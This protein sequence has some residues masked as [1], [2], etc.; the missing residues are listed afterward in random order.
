[1]AENELVAISMVV[2]KYENQGDMIMSKKTFRLSLCVL[3]AAALVSCSDSVNKDDKKMSY[4]V[5]RANQAVKLGSEWDVGQ[6]KRANVLEIAKHMGDK[7]EHFPRTQAKVLYDDENLYVFFRV[8]DQ[9]VRAVTEQI[10]GS[11]CRDSCVEFFFTPGQTQ[12]QDEYFNIEINCGGTILMH[13][14]DGDMSNRKPLDAADCQM[15]EIYH[16]LPKI[17]EQE[18]TKPTVWFVQYKLPIALLEKHSSIDKP[19]SGVVW[20]ANFYKCADLTSH[21]HWLTWSFVDNPTPNFHLPQHF[22]LLNFE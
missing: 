3:L 12:L 15:I 10:N 5:R 18:I 11:V 14:G 21:P 22:G 7:P 4:T 2:G 9:Y 16:S 17:I 19:Q 1:V 8:E 6:W 20:K 13:Y